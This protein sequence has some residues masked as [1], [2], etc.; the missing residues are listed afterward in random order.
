M[1]DKNNT[2]FAYN[3]G[4][5][6]AVGDYI[7][8]KVHNDKCGSL[9]SAGLDKRAIVRPVEC[10]SAVLNRI[11]Q[12]ASQ[13]SRSADKQWVLHRVTK[14]VDEITTNMKGHAGSFSIDEQAE[15]R[16]AFWQQRQEFY[17]KATNTNNTNKKD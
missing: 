17:N 7:Q 12:Y 2:S 8:Y 13:I 14:L 1:L 10:Q 15:M 16:C 11:K 6:L 5:L 3:L 4:R 9:M